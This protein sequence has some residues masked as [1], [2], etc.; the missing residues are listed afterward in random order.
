MVTAPACVSLLLNLKEMALRSA[1]CFYVP[2]YSLICIRKFPGVIS[3]LL[4]RPLETI[5]LH[6]GVGLLAQQ[7]P[8]EFRQP[9]HMEN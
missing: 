3:Q 9:N 8:Y 2:V 4:S 1:I 7:Y 5:F 6:N